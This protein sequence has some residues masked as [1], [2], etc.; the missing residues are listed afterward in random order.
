MFT[1]ECICIDEIQ[2]GE[3]FE[4]FNARKISVD[5]IFKL[6]I[7]NYMQL[8]EFCIRRSHGIDRF[9]QPR[10]DEFDK[11]LAIHHNLLLS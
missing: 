1:Y 3:M 11:F 7:I 5:V 8:G 6:Y 9:F 2:F 10:R 4:K